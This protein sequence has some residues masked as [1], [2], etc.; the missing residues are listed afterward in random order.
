MSRYYD[1]AHPRGTIPLQIS[2][3]I[4]LFANTDWYLF[5]FRLALA[6]HLRDELGA[7]VFV[8]CPD[9]PYRPGLEAEGFQW[10]PVQMGRQSLNP[11][12][13]LLAALRLGRVLRS[14][15][16]DLIHSFTL[17]SILIGSLAARMAGVPRAVN[18][19]TGLGSLFSASKASYALPRLLLTGFFRR[20]FRSPR[21][22]TI[23]QNQQD[24]QRLASSP[25]HQAA[26]RLIPGSGVDPV[27]FSPAAEP[28]CHPVLILASR[29]LKDKGIQDFCE[30]ATRIKAE[31]PDA[32]F[33]VAGTIDTG[34][35]GSFS[36]AEIE[37]LKAR[38]PMVDFL[39]HRED[40]P[41]LYRQSA[42]AVLPSRY[43]EG[44]PRSL[45]EAAASGLPL[46]AADGDGVVPIVQEGRNGHRVPPGDPEALAQAL[47]SLLRDPEILA[48]YGRES[49]AI[50]LAGFDQKR[51]LDATI[52]VYG[53]LGFPAPSGRQEP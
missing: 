35:P 12:P 40:M 43:G 32:A 1:E 36:A 48:R 41:E 24:L 8:A 42:I 49:R 46:V 18:A 20:T 29:L 37:T 27:R 3:R 33:W 50:L 21:I 13:D 30:A 31:L 53:E 52:A 28:P 9:G 16:P 38:Y 7:K 45:L 5:N 17:K 39:G 10:I 15:E 23:F 11:F 19:V 47:L 14:L 51:V 4:V 6:R 34:S 26:C 44:V 25:R 22:R 2:P